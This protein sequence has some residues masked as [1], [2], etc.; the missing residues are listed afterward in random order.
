MLDIF[1]KLESL[2]F[3]Q[4][5]SFMVALPNVWFIYL[6]HLLLSSCMVE[7]ISKKANSTPMTFT[8]LKIIGLFQLVSLEWRCFDSW[9]TLTAKQWLLDN[10][11]LV[12]WHQ[13]HQRQRYVFT[14]TESSSKRLL[15]VGATSRPPTGR[16]TYSSFS[17]HLLVLYERENTQFIQNFTTRSPS[18][19]R[20]PLKT[21]FRRWWPILFLFQ[22][23]RCARWIKILKQWWS[24][25]K[26]WICETMT[27]R[28]LIRV[29]FDLLL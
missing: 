12:D 6:A 16:S 1:W 23:E 14:F 10:K 9:S 17:A 26:A 20:P 3:H 8:N 27:P 18:S 19:S 2:F 29:G 11:A 22:D 5:A 15:G 21:M 25:F 28:L 13:Y 7:R 4:M 24:T